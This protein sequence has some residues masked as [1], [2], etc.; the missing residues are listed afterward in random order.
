MVRLA[1]RVDGVSLRQVNQLF[2]R[3]IDEN[4]ANQGGKCFFG[5][6]GNVADEGTGV[7]GHENNTQEGSPQPDTG[8][9]GEV[10]EGIVPA[11]HRSS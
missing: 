10:R 9:Q 6:A 3:F 5:E 2:Y 11:K 4:N 8:S 7:S 1:V